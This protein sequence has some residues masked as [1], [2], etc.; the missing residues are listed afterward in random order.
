MDRATFEAELAR[1]NYTPVER[2]RPANDRDAEHT[3]GFDARLLILEGAM[4]IHCDGATR[5]YGPGETFEM[6][7]GHPHAEEIGPEGVAYL[8]GRRTAAG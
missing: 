6:P 4:T 5:T 7:A 1:D 2:R 8:A 3:H